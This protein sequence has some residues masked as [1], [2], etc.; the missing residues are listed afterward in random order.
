MYPKRKNDFRVY[1]PI[2]NKQKI[3]FIVIRQKRQVSRETCRFFL[4][5]ELKTNAPKAQFSL[6]RD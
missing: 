3:Y 6:Y 1:I 2:E 4:H 5:S